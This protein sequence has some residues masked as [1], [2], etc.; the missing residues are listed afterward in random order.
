VLVAEACS[1]HPQ[2]DDIARIK[3]PAL[4]QGHLGHTLRF[5]FCAGVDFPEDIGGYALVL[6]CGGCMLSR[7]EMRRRLRMTA[8]AGV[9]VSNY[10]MA[11]SLAQGILERVL[12]PFDGMGK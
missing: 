7:R 1:H 11:I 2:S 12:R 5:S 6:H 3:I 10:G 9:P 4:L 8:A